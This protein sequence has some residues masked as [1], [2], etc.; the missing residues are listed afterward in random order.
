MID[1]YGKILSESRDRLQKI[2]KE[3]DNLD[4]VNVALPGDIHN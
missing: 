4:Q 1:R 2:D 3:L